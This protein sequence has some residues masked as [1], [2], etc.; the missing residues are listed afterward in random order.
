MGF[1]SN[2]TRVVIATNGRDI[3][4]AAHGTDL[5][6][7]FK[8]KGKIVLNAA[9]CALW[10]EQEFVYVGD[11]AI[12]EPSGKTRRLGIDL[13]LRYDLTNWLYLKANINYTYA[14]SSEEP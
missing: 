3:L 8:P 13:G 5:G 2:D 10:L 11:A 6:L 14:R 9:L 4:P 7:V 12:V 1:H